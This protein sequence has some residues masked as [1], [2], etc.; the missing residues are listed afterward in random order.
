MRWAVR[1]GFSDVGSRRRLRW[2]LAAL[3]WILAG[4]G[5]PDIPSVPDNS[6]I[7][8]QFLSKPRIAGP[9][10]GHYAGAGG[11]T[12]GF[13]AYRSERPDRRLALVYFHGIESHADWFDEAARRLQTQGIDVFCLDR[14]GSGINR[15]NRGF[16]SGHADSMAQLLADV[17]AFVQPLHGH[18]GRVVLVGLSWGGKLALAYGLEHPDAADG[19][20]LITPGLRSLVDVSGW[21]KLGILG[22]SWLAPRT[23]FA[24]PIEAPMFTTTPRHLDYI[25]SDPLRLTEA[26]AGFFMTSVAFDRYID[27][28]IADNRLPVLLFLAGRDRIIDNDAVLSL[29]EMGKG[30]GLEVRQYPEQTHSIQFDAPEKMVTDISGWLAQRIPAD[31]VAR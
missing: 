16:P 10:V 12:L 15:E 9:D 13:K 17:D 18:Y 20:V 28:R 5:P 11:A 6:A 14:R 24:V 19:L 30:A 4:C 22:A 31:E 21:T 25:R 23:P 7:L 29:L 8:D 2:S 27:R 3:A 26:S 1:H